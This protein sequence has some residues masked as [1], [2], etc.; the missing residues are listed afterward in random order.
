MKTDSNI[1]VWSEIYEADHGILEYPDSCFITLMHRYLSP[2]RHQNVLDFG[3]GGGA[4][5]FAMI[6]RGHSVTGIEISEILINKVKSKMTTKAIDGKL[7]CLKNETLPFPDHSFDAI[8]SWNVLG[9]NSHTSLQKQLKELNRVLKPGGTAIASIPAYGDV[10][11]ES[12]TPINDLEFISNYSNQ[13]G[14]EILFLSS[15]SKVQKIIG[16]PNLEVELYQVPI[17]NAQVSRYWVFLY[18]KESN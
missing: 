13:T 17:F 1:K 12:A 18:Q 11:H 15:K 10:S 16:W 14:A 9:Y 2:V 4:N 7:Y 3:F 8:T 5:M 6:K